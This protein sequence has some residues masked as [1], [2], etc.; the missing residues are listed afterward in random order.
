MAS[1]IPRDDA[2]A[3]VLEAAIDLPRTNQVSIPS[4]PSGRQQADGS[5]RQGQGWPAIDVRRDM[6]VEAIEIIHHLHRAS[7]LIRREHFR[8]DSA[9]I[10][11]LAPR[12]SVRS[13]SAGSSA[14]S[15]EDGRSTPTSRQLR[16]SLVPRSSSG[17]RMSRRRSRAGRTSTRSSRPSVPSGRAASPTS[18]SC[19]S[20]TRRS[21]G[22]W[23]RSHHRYSRS[24]ASSGQMTSQ[25]AGSF[26]S[27]LRALRP[28]TI[29]DATVKR[30]TLLER[31][32]RT[33]KLNARL[34]LS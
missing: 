26:R 13:P 9:R 20:A 11:D 32:T 7:A 22:S 4:P 19:R 21:N 8:V 17:P 28:F 5:P 23:R 33:R 27:V 31:D 2:N 16:V 3:Q 10:W 34:S 1:Q 18:L 12:P 15:Q 14:G 25:L 30:R 29:S 6:L 24:C